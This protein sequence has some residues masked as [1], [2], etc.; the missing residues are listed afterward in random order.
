MYQQRATAEG[1]VKRNPGHNERP[2][3]LSRSFYAGSQKCA[4]ALVMA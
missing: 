3:V 4:K 1:L 2:F